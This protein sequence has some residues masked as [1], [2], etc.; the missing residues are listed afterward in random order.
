MCVFGL[1]NDHFREKKTK[2]ITKTIWKEYS[3]YSI[4]KVRYSILLE[5]VKTPQDSA[6]EI[7]DVRD[8]QPCSRHRLVQVWLRGVPA[9]D[10]WV[11]APTAPRLQQYSES[12]FFGPPD[13]YT[14]KF[15]QGIS[16]TRIPDTECWY[17]R[18]AA[19]VCM[20]NCVCVSLPN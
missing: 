12:H 6:C 11:R 2:K 10:D 1:K 8:S 18:Q 16:C 17:W 15:L 5:T 14:L 9:N 7:L 3:R 20:C 19:K 13:M 4:L